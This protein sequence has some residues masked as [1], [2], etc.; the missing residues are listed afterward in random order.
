MTMTR[1]IKKVI[2]WNTT[3][4]LKKFRV[5]LQD[6]EKMCLPQT[7]KAP[8]VKRTTTTKEL[9]LIIYFY[10]TKCIFREIRICHYAL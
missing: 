2:K 1:I 10:T 6:A 9:L 7:W 5:N 3:G 4:K 8:I